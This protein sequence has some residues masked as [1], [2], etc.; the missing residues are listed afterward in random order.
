MKGIGKLV[1]WGTLPAI[2]TIKRVMD[3]PDNLT[4]SW[5]KVDYKEPWVLRIILPNNADD[6]ISLLLS[7]LQ[8]QGCQTNKKYEKRQKLEESEVTKAGVLKQQNQINKILEAIEGFENIIWSQEEQKDELDKEV[9]QQLIG[10]YNKAITFYSAVNDE[11]HLEILQKLQRLLQDERI[12]KML[13]V[14]DLTA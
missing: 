12:Q 4:I 8:K 1:S 9:V 10:L 5:R 7:H 2:D 6:F 13:E 3:Q 11:R 14:I